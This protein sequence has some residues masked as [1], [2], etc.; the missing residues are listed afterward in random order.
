MGNDH[1]GVLTQKRGPWLDPQTG[2]LA[3]ATRRIAAET[4][5]DGKVPAGP[6]AAW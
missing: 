3:E 1:A 4:T 6:I 5:F 2:R